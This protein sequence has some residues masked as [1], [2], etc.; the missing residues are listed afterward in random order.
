M[1]HPTLVPKLPHRAPRDLSQHGAAQDVPLLTWLRQARWRQPPARLPWSR[2]R[3]SCDWWPSV[4]APGPEPGSCGCHTDRWLLQCS[5]QWARRPLWRASRPSNWTRWAAASAWATPTIWVWGRWV[6]Y[7]PAGRRRQSVEESRRFP[8]PEHASQSLSTNAYRG[9]RVAQALCWAW[10]TSED[11]S[12]PSL[13][14]L[15]FEPRVALTPNLTLSSAKPGPRA[16]PEGPRSPRLYEL[17]PQSADGEVGSRVGFD[18]ILRVDI[19]HPVPDSP[20]VG[21]PSGQRRLPDGV[22]G[23]PVRSDGGGRPLPFPLW[24]WWDPSEP[25]EVCGDPERA[26]WVDPG[27][28][29]LPLVEVKWACS[30]GD[31]GFGQGPHPQF[32]HPEWGSFTKI[33]M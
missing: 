5:C 6:G 32:N 15:T 7:A 17:A 28:S 25:R 2:P 33:V 16:D 8:R 29:L 10:G 1:V 9:S 20:A 13:S 3:G 24:R 31:A 12:W 14:P 4:A 30:F 11:G 22:P 18:G 19:P 23:V 21:S 26:R 27:E